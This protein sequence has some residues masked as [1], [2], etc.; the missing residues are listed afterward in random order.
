MWALGAVLVATVFG[1]LGAGNESHLTV[2]AL[3]PLVAAVKSQM[4]VQIRLVNEGSVA[5]G[6]VTDVGPLAGMLTAVVGQLVF[7]DK[8]AR[9][10]VA[11]VGLL[12]VVAL[13]MNSQLSL[14]CKA[15]AALVTGERLFTAVCFQ[16]DV[17]IRLLIK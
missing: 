10:L 12:T 5:V 11:L 15:F 6:N 4:F 2:L 13:Q 9:A 8:G 1:Q 17:Q 7:G 14:Q 3:V 16:V